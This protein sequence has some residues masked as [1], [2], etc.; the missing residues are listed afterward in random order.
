MNHTPGPWYTAETINGDILII[1][2]DG[3]SGRQISVVRSIVDGLTEQEQLANARLMA[4]APDLLKAL[5]EVLY[6]DCD[7][8]NYY[9]W[10]RVRAAI[11]KSKGETYA[12]NR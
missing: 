7:S 8:Y 3:E 12:I 2:K 9:M 5:E 1:A 6:T 10:E 4:S 11:A